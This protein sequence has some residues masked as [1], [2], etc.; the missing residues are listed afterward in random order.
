MRTPQNHSVKTIKGICTGFTAKA[1]F[2]E[3]EGGY[4]ATFPK[5]QIK[6]LAGEVTKGAA[7]TVS[8][9]I[10]I[11]EQQ[12]HAQAAD[13]YDPKTPTLITGF[14]VDTREKAIAVKCDADMV[15]RWLA[16]SQINIKEGSAT[17]GDV[18][19]IIAPAWML[20]HTSGAY[21]SWTKGA[22]V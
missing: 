19:R 15:T 18:V 6:I 16:L 2:L 10:W 13:S 3:G 20:K 11:I 9:P 8:V 12:H 1:L 17:T 4:K 22:A 5:S 7:V 21:P 14:I